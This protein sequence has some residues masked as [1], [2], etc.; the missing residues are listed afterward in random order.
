MKNLKHSKFKNTGVLFELLVRQV[1]SDTLNNNDSKAIPLIKKHFSKSTEL[2]KEFNL[3][4]TLVKERFSKEEKASHLIEAVMS[5]R[6]AIN[7]TILNR[8]KYNLIKE[9]KSNY[10]LEDFFKSKVNN[11]KT[12]AAIYKLFE[13]TVADN[14]VESVNNK[15][16]I[17]EHITRS[18]DVKK[19]SG[20]NE[21]SAFI[22]Q[23]KD[24]RLLSYK[25]LVDKFNAKYSDLNEGQKSLL[26]HYINSVSE[27]TELKEFIEKE[28]LKLQKELKV[29]TTKVT[30]KVV[31][32]KLAEVTNLL[33]EVAAVKTVKD[34]HVLNLLR[35]HE[36]I[37]ELKKA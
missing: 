35:Y 4:Q 36:L 29:L 23:D 10:N 18:N 5:A 11:Y 21:M 28:S 26:R 31:K 32:I 15:Y 30:D 9:I 7:Q 13:Y 33:K 16:T 12:L 6:S 22:N 37:K 27:G 24:V 8:Q 2:A 14:P 1:A 20:L 3:Y 19:T 17:I 25:I 34:N